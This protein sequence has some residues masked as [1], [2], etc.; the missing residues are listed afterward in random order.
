MVQGLHSSVLV[1]Q[2]L[3][4]AGEASKAVWGQRDS[5]L[6]AGEITPIWGSKQTESGALLGILC[7]RCQYNLQPVSCPS[8]LWGLP[9]REARD[10]GLRWSLVLFQ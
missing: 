9:S 2:W 6:P 4:R 5:R 7:H 1:L 8:R 3:I 10:A